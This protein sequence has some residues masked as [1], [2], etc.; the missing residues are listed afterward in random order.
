MKPYLTGEGAIF[1]QA[2]GPGTIL[3][4]LGCHSLDEI[5]EPLGELTLLTRPDNRRAN[6]FIPTGIVQSGID[7]ITT[8]IEFDLDA[9]ADILENLDCPFN[10]YVLK[11]P[12]GRKDQFTNWDRAFILEGVMVSNRKRSGMVAKTPEQQGSSMQTL[13]VGAMALHA[14]SKMVVNEQDSDIGA[15]RTALCL[16]FADHA[17]CWGSCGSAQAPNEIGFYGL[18]GVP[19]VATNVYWTDDG[20]LNWYPTVANP[21]A[22]VEDVTG[23]VM[24]PAS[25][26]T[27]RVICA[28]GTTDAGNPMEVGYS[29]DGGVTW[30]NVNV[31]A[32]NGQFAVGKGN[33]MFALNRANIWLCTTGGY[34]YKSDDQGLSW[35]AQESGGTTTEDL[36]AIHFSD[37]KH[38]W[39]V[40]ENNTILKTTN[41]G[42]DWELVTG[43]ATEGGNNALC[44]Y[45]INS[46]WVWV[47]YQFS[48][49]LYKTYNGGDDGWFEVDFP[50]SGV[51]DVEAVSFASNF[52][53]LVTHTSLGGATGNLFRTVNGGYSWA[54]QVLPS[55]TQPMYAIWMINCNLAYMAGEV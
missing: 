38:G 13:D 7:V 26:T 34:I 11:I 27:D 18:E 14:I 1:I 19:L 54:T 46:D 40:G 8:T 28:R 55:G 17:R 47:G 10:L 50:G 4:F 43:P 9:V 23:I 49:R 41:G 12:C 51:G 2:D 52:S 53:G 48:G 21:F 20:G 44:V 37:D 22:D 24:I 16:A 33:P 5:N 30:T 15:G 39:C 36:Y 42:S 35:T 29:D 31:G 6:K 3:D 32:V 45:A 25:K